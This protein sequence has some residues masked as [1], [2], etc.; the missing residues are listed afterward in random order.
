MG[1]EKQV[2]VLQLTPGT[3]IPIAELNKIDRPIELRAPALRL[4]FADALI[5]LYKR[6]GA[7]QGVKRKILQPD[8]TV[9]SVPQVKVLQE[10][11]RHLSPDF[12]HSREEIRVVEIKRPVKA[13][14]ER[15]RLVRVVDFQIRQMR[16]RQGR[17]L[18]VM[19]G[20]LQVYAEEEQQISKFYVVDGCQR[21][22]LEDARHRVRVFQLRQPG[23]GDLKLGILLLLGNAKTQVF[24]VSRCDSQTKTQFPELVPRWAKIHTE[25]SYSI[26]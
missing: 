21:V 23:V 12:N 3:G 18:L 11:D 15:D 5:D 24:D 20:L 22:Q 13:N 17:K 26:R 7:E 2:P 19:R 16:F 8:V 10:R 25:T 9:Q 6:A 14:W 1:Q 4:D